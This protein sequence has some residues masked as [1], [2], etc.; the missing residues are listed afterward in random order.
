VT[1]TA[2]MPHATG[3]APVPPTAA[4]GRTV[5]GWDRI[6]A[7]ALVHTATAVAAEALR[8]PVADVRAKVID[9]GRGALAVEVTGPLSIMPLGSHRP[10]SEPVLA[11]AHRARGQIA[12]RITSI[13]G[14]HVSRVTVVFTSAAVDRA[15]RV[16]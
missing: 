6:G 15:D 10:P 1:A 5:A 8:A 14:R 9:D 4:D 16:R 7:A 13:T 12:E 3:S 11:T 2:A